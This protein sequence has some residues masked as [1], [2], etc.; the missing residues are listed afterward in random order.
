M[1]K[2]TIGIGSSANDGTGD[3]LRDGAI[4]ANANFTEIYDKLGDSTNVLIDIAGGIT[5]GQVLKWTSSPTPAFRGSDYNL[6]SSNL[7][8]NGNDIVSDGT[9]AIT[10]HQ[11]GTGHINLRAG[12]SGSAYTRIDGTTGYL[13]W[14]APYATEGDL[15]SA[16]DQHGMFA[17][18]HGTGKGYFAHAAAWVKL[19]DYNDGI[20]A[21]TDVDTTVNG[22]PSDGQVLKWNAGNS[23]WEP[24]NDLQS[25]GG[26]GGTTQ[27][28]F[29]TFTGDT[30]T[31]TASAA[32]DTLNIVGGTNISTAMSGDTLTITMTGSLGAPDQNIFATLGADNATITANTTSDTLTF[33]GGTGITTNA[34]AGAITITNDSPNV[35]Q[36]V[37]QAIS[38]DSGSYTAVASD[39][40]VTIAGGTG[41][42]TA[43]SGNT[44]TITNTVALPS[45]SEGQSLLYGTSS[46]EAVASPTVSYAFTS[47]GN[48]NYYIVNGPGISNGQ[49]T[50]IYVYRGFTYRFD[51]VTGSGHPLAIRVSDGGS[52]VSNVSG[53]VNGVQYWTVPQTLA[54]GTTYVYQCTIHGNMKGD[55]VVV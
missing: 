42:S 4:K 43:V 40:S 27:N 32:N 26:G 30:G 15:P 29:E 28:L 33:T 34:N 20:S 44:L 37:L 24:A 6:L 21:L 13:T 54:A 48:T 45:A 19:V 51:N 16:T 9:D 2:Q 17:H 14:Y 49:D 41:V 36:N 46:Y 25:G 7:D 22:G 52:S 10:I 50:T 18:V 3:T 31:T 53:S 47:D 5:E 12:G 8:T 39:S 35:V 11:T 23:A 55:I 38:G 1:A